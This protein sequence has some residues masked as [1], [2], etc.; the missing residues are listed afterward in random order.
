MGQQ[1]AVAALVV[2]AFGAGWLARGGPEDAGAAGPEPLAR[3]AARAI[4]EAVEAAGADAAPA[5]LAARLGARLPELE[6]LDDRLRARGVADGAAEAMDD[7]LNAL[8]AAR[9]ALAR[10]EERSAP[11]VGAA[12]ARASEAAGR[13]G[14]SG[15]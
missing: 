3:A 14:S 7:A 15:A 9:R 2:L 5:A 12:L 13:L 10:G 6:A 1:L 11:G 8:V 4:R